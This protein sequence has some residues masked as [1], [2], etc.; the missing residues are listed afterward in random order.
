MRSH[1]DY[2]SDSYER[3]YRKRRGD[4]TH[5]FKAG[6][7]D[8]KL[9]SF[10]GKRDVTKALAFIRQFEVAFVHEKFTEKS[11][12]RHV[13]MYLTETAENWWLAKIL[14]HS[15]AK[16]WTLF[17]EQFYEQFLPLDF[18]KDVRKEW[19]WISQK[20]EESVS[21][22]VDSFWAVLLRVTPFMKISIHK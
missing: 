5:I 7:K 6:D 9:K 21:Q 22:Y 11:K 8:I 19:D 3:R 15:D 10:D 16:T 20:E 13:G 4:S 17:K 12:L 14:E 2:F 18:E 1:D